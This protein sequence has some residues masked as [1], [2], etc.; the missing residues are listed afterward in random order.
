MIRERNLVSRDDSSG[1]RPVHRVVRAVLTV[2]A[3]AALIGGAIAAS[4][5]IKS[6]EPTA[7]RESAT[8]KSSALVET[9]TVSRGTW[10]PTI[11]ALGSVQ[12]AREIV[13]SPRVG[14]AIAAVEPTFMLGG[15]VRAG[16][17]LLRIDAADYEYELALRESEMQQVLAELAIE[18]GQ[19]RVAQ[20]EFE[21]LGEDIAP[22]N[23]AL[24]LREPQIA[25]LRAKLRA[26]EAAVAHA[27]RNVAR[28]EVVAPFAAQI[29]ERSVELGS[30]VSAGDALARLVG[31]DTY[32]V[33]ATVPLGTL[34]WIEF[35]SDGHAGATATIRHPAAW[36]ADGARTGTVR[37]L[38]GEVDAMTRLARVIVTV[39]RPL[40]D[41]DEPGMILGAV[42]QLA[43]DARPIA[44][45]VRL[46]RAYLR[47]NDTVWVMEDGALR[48]RS[49]DVVFTDQA[50]AY[51]RAGL[52]AGDR[53]VTTDLATVVDGLP[54]RALTPAEDVR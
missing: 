25:S 20:R 6:S 42:V 26:A 22:E 16:S 2:I 14:G 38:I 21:L 24:V 47:Q 3:V 43:I 36:G 51:V 1:L 15:M 44:D 46:E 10:R 11:R 34:R 54:I 45:V 39:P 41:G 7:Q 17:P 5:W 13:L 27:Q 48:I 8:R 52:E 28:T 23:R 40:G 53:I 49:V 35:P 18:E 50:F 33:V 32:W 31:I 19:Q 29:L 37:E 12:P 30:E 9:I 4:V